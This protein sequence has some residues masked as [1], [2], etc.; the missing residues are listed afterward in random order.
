M[1]SIVVGLPVSCVLDMVSIWIWIIPVSSQ[2]L[3]GKMWAL[4][5]LDSLLG[6]AD[7]AD[8]AC[9]RAPGSRD[10]RLLFACQQKHM[11]H[12]EAKPSKHVLPNKADA[13]TYTCCLLHSRDWYREE[14]KR[15]TW[16][17]CCIWHHKRPNHWWGILSLGLCNHYFEKMCW[18]AYKPW[19]LTCISS[20][21]LVLALLSTSSAN[22]SKNA[23]P[24]KYFHLYGALATAASEQRRHD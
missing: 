20:D 13:A 8:H 17:D 22:S 18:H 4:M 10:P 21:Q 2:W 7:A 9:R 19:Q 23:I 6:Q 12:H 16:V 5:P 24:Q 14:S 1:H 11:H 15:C 3:E